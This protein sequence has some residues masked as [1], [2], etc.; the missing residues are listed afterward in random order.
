[1]ADREVAAQQ[2]QLPHLQ[3]QL[4]LEPQE[5]AFLVKVLLARQVQLELLVLMAQVAA[6]AAQVRLVLLLQM[7]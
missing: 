1:M 4:R 3:P 5:Q 2:A 6:E 7:A